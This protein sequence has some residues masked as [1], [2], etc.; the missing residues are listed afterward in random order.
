[1]RHVK[2]RKSDV[3]DCQWL[4]QLHSFGLLCKA[5]RPDEQVCA[6][7]EMSRLRDITI[8]ERA[9]HTQRMQKAL[10]PMNVQLT[11]VITKLTGETGMNIITAVAHKLARIVYAMLSGQG[12]LR[13][14]RLGQ[15]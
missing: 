14:I 7:R 10:T 3:F 13:Q 9:R 6:L 5:H 1:M 8:E 4:Q 15:A 12:R 2:A 11:N